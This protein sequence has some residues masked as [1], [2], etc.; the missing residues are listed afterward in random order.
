VEQSGSESEVHSVALLLRCDLRV[1]L[2]AD[3]T[4]GTTSH[5]V[6][7]VLDAGPIIEQDVMRVSHRHSVQ[8]LVRAGRDLEKVVLSRAIWSHLQRKIIVHK[9]RTIVFH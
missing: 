1:G 8:E 5:Y 3:L 2:A 6:A 4:I 9:G 7:E